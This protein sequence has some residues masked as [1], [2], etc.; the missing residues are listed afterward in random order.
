MPDVDHDTLARWFHIYRGAPGHMSLT[1]FKDGRNQ[2]H[3]YTTDTDGIANAMSQANRLCQ[4]GY[5]VYMRTTTVD[6]DQLEDGRRGGAD[7]TVAVIGIGTDL[8]HAQGA[9]K[10][11]ELLPPTPDDALSLVEGMPRPS[12]VVNSGGGY[13]AWWLFNA[14]ST[15]LDLCAPLLKEWN[16]HIIAKAAEHG[17]QV[18][19]VGDLPRI[20]RPVG[21]W[22][23]KTD[24]PKQVVVEEHTGV[25]YTPEQLRTWLDKH[26][27][28][29]PPEPTQPPTLPTSTTGDD[30]TAKIKRVWTSEQELQA[31][32]IQVPP[33]GVISCPFPSHDDHT[34][35]FHIYDEAEE[36]WACFGSSCPS[37]GGGSVIDLVMHLDSVDVGQAIRQL[38]H[39]IGE[40]AP[41]PSS[42]HLVDI[43]MPNQPQTGETTQ[44][45][46]DRPQ[47][48]DNI[49]NDPALLDPSNPLHSAVWTEYQ[50]LVARRQAQR[51]DVAQ[52][53][54]D[55]PPAHSLT[56]L[57]A[58][59][60]PPIT[61]RVVGLWPSDGRVL[62]AAQ[63]KAGKSTMMG[64]LVRSL[65]DG[66]P[67]LGQ[68]PVTPLN[69][70]VTL[71]DDELHI[72]TI[73]RWYRDQGIDNTDAVDI[74]PLRGN[75]STFN[76]L[77]PNIRSQWAARLAA[78][79]TEIVV[80]D[81]LRP[82][83]DSLGLSEDKES[84]V[85]LTAFDELCEEA[86]VTEAVVVH[87]MGHS[88]ERSR[89]DSRLRD[90]P[91]VEWRMIRDDDAGHEGDDIPR[92][93]VAYGR[94]VDEPERLLGHDPDSRELTIVGG[95]RK[96]EA[97]KWAMHNVLSFIDEA[98]DSP[99]QRRIVDGVRGRASE[100]RRLIETAVS[101]GFVEVI[102]S[103]QTKAHRLT[104]S[105]RHKM[106]QPN[107]RA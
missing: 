14:P 7:E 70:R 38:A 83:L 36:G 105:G 25:R 62:L 35:S 51:I 55:P 5:D 37:T 30:L 69:G 32:G 75:T 21:T 39:R 50:R 26:G 52:N 53:T 77:D 22:S 57:L 41:P 106:N 46:P 33:S 97:A 96:E 87:H 15:D 18:D 3:H 80:F 6:A 1:A 4:D 73:R 24:E 43:P 58:Q 68:H 31:R 91:D 100:V 56:E 60:D 82:I 34:P 74:I 84:G 28:H 88:G 89:G 44:E 16:A 11:T 72:N 66:Q 81:C 9:H 49:P 64:N 76:I 10:R 61:Y 12:I 20:L 29:R 79:A 85:F 90:W 92:Y 63:H 13:Y 65:V 101:Q 95:S 102:E 47:T 54:P 98:G 107:R 71:I 27:L 59:P 45:D 78:A 23:Y 67:F 8:D 104:E 103:G 2:S 94:D 48:A 19:Q 42:P 93:F 86:G 17:W 40:P 99:S